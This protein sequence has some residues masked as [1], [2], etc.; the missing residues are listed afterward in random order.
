MAEVKYVKFADGA[1][2]EATQ[3]SDSIQDSADGSK[4]EQLLLQIDTED[5]QN[6]L[7]DLADKIT[8]AGLKDVNIYSDADCKKQ[9]F[10][11][12]AYKAINNV[13]ATVRSCGLLY[14]VMLD[15]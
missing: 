9:I 1:V 11:G 8:D 14:S 12:G 13:T 3:V 2:I 7:K 15:K 4:T 5:T 6:K 10:A